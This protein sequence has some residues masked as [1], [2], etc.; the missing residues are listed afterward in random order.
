[1]KVRSPRG[2]VTVL[3]VGT[4]MSRMAETGEEVDRGDAWTT[5]GSVPTGSVGKEPVAAAGRIRHRSGGF[6][7]AFPAIPSR[8][9]P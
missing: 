1:M 9:S 2:L 4:A 7:R 8:W 5:S 6:G 3:R